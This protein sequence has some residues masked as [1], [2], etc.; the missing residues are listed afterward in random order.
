MTELLHLTDS[1]LRAFDATVLEAA[2][3][4]VLLDR[5]AF[6]AT[7]GGQPH[8]TGSLTDGNQHWDVVNVTK[9]GAD[10]FCHLEPSEPLPTVGTQVH[11]ELDWSRRY[12]LMRMHT[13]LHVLCGV[14]FR[15]YGALV[16]GGN[17][18]PA[19]ARIDFELEDLSP[20]RVAHIERVANA[21]IQDGRA[22]TWRSLPRDEAFQIPDLIRTKINLLPAHIRDVRVVEIQGLDLQADGGTHVRNTLEVGGLRVVG[23]RSKGRANK[24]LEIVLT[25]NAPPEGSHA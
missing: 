21:A 25:P 2:D 7:G 10:V 23:T 24:R 9:R 20:A 12:Q 11:G 18:T 3:G 5:C 15:E 6:Y 19:G 4:A 13:A 17:M 1:Y 22:V 8:D 16:T 14:V